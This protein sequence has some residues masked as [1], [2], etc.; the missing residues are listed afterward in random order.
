MKTHFNLATVPLENHRRFVVGASMLG[1]LSLAA[2][3]FL[4]VSVLHTW[5]S[6]RVIRIDI[7]QLESRLQTEQRQQDELRKA[8]REKDAVKILDRAAYLN[9][10]IEERAFPW[11]KMFGD[12]ERILPA[13]VRVVSLQPGRDKQ[14]N[15]KV[16]I[17]IGAQNDDVKLKFL[18][19]LEASPAF[20]N[21]EVTQE[22]RPTKEL[23]TSG[24]QV[25]LQ[26]QAQYST[27]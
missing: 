6:S 7:S 12:L 18:Q 3:G 23:N 24:D 1:M 25:L 17:T 19:A 15:V 13:G 11:T 9:G 5:R 22:A 26:L 2:M 8:F 4:A 27:I 14:G 20:S 21:V 10:L 16:I